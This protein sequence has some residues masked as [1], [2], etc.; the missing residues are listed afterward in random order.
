MGIWSSACPPLNLLLLLYPPFKQLFMVKV[1]EQKWSKTS[2]KNIPLISIFYLFFH[3]M[4]W[5]LKWG[6]ADVLPT[7]DGVIRDK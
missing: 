2:G 5:N 6:H 3:E 7:E 4:T 1:C